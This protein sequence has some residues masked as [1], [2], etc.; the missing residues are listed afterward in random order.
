MDRIYR[1]SRA[2]LIKNA[3]SKWFAY[4]VR[5]KAI[6]EDVSIKFPTIPFLEKETKEEAESLLVLMTEQEL[7]DLLTAINKLED[8]PVWTSK[9]EYPRYSD[10][11]SP[12]CPLKKLCRS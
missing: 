11:R 5:Y 6:K 1:C 8:N 7:R 4:G 10:S 9:R 3:M 12:W 2:N